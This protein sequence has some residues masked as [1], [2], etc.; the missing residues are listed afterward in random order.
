MQTENDQSVSSDASLLMMWEK[1]W[2]D[3]RKKLALRMQSSYPVH[4][5]I[6]LLSLIFTGKINVRMGL[7]SGNPTGLINSLEMGRVQIREMR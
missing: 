3:L 6:R 5:C 7:C 2:S 4:V 1:I